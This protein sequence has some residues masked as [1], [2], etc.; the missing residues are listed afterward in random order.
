MKG[1]GFVSAAALTPSPHGGI[2][3][4]VLPAILVG[5]GLP[6]ELAK[7]IGIV[8]GG[9]HGIFLIPRK[10][11]PG[12]SQQGKDKWADAREE[13]AS[14]LLRLLGVSSL[15][16]LPVVSNTTFFA[17]LAGF[18]S[19][20]DWIGSNE[21]YFSH[22]VCNS[23][24]DYAPRSYQRATKALDWSGWAAW[25]PPE[26][27]PSFIDLFPSF[28]EPRPLQA[29]AVQVADSLGDGPSLVIIEAPMGE[30]KTEAA[31]YVSDRKVAGEKLK[32][33]YFALPTQA[34]SNQMYSRVCSFLANRYPGENVIPLL[35]HGNALLADSFN[36]P[37]M[38]WSAND[39]TT[40]LEAMEWFLPR[41]RGLLAPFGVGTVDQPLLSV[42]QTKHFFV[43]LFGLAHKVVIVDEIHAYDTY[44]STLLERLLAWLR[45]LGS[46]VI[47]LSAT[48][49]ARK[50]KD[51]VRA[52]GGKP[53]ALPSSA[54]PR[55]TWVSSSGQG[56]ED[57]SVSKRLRLRIHHILEDTSKLVA[58]VTNALG[59]GGCAAIV[60]NTV[61][62]A[63]ETY[64]AFKTAGRLPPGE[65]VLLHS[66]YPFEER[67]EKEAAILGALSPQGQ[68]PHR[69]LLIATQ[70]IEQSLDL[71]FD[72]MVTDLAPADLVLQRAGRLHRHSNPRPASLVEPNLWVR[73]P[74]AGDNGI[75]DFGPSAYVYEEYI[76][77]LSYLALKNRHGIRLPEDIETIVEEVYG[78]GDHGWPSQAFG[79]TA[80]NAKE[81]MAANFKHEQA[82]ARGNLIQRPDGGAS[83]LEFLNSLD[84]Q[85]EEDSPD[86]HQSLQAL[87]R[88][89]EP[90]VRVVCL[91]RLA[92]GL[93]SHPDDPTPVDLRRANEH[94]I[95]R[96]LLGRS[97]TINH[98]G[99]VFELLNRQPP[100]EF[101]RM[102]H[103]RHHRL[104]EFE[105][106]V[107]QVGRYTI[108]LDKE[109]GLMVQGPEDQR[110]E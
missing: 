80:V 17:A 77:L 47:L 51:L 21:D 64:L 26:T 106:G 13:L 29:M 101:R 94:S 79:A 18:V 73:M 88:L 35:V 59:D 22:H 6:N 93:F 72:L 82:V 53:A 61:R 58:E 41:K 100:S 44:M 71:D 85:L 56:Q 24:D 91:H 38:G 36:K 83:P 95:T 23:P 45:A 66:R 55:I 2:T 48:L 103:L 40:G 75:P 98:K 3:A 8:L 43:R 74:D 12:P 27:A 68:R 62:R 63:Q 102:A 19:V 57:F 28:K 37:H 104:L 89:A 30:G 108:R 39:E 49:P 11:A 81:Q 4:A 5:Q 96:A 42:L 31:M 52:F 92:Q 97:V 87:T 60:C 86:L 90:S 46:S 105:E 16:R 110:E 67:Q 84:K 1:R 69:M 50:T 14:E 7:S 9:H 65:L 78:D 10:G 33:C 109:L 15:P 20:A 54:Y 99:V 107:A 70:I 25:E 34:T 76:L 32:G